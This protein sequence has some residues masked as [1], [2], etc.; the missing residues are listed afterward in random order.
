MKN[1]SLYRPLVKTMIWSILLC[2]A[3]YALILFLSNTTIIGSGME[4]I[5]KIVKIVKFI[6]V[7]IPTILFVVSISK[8]WKG[9]S[10]H[11]NLDGYILSAT[12]ALILFCCVLYM[13][14]TAPI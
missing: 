13:L 2:A 3:S 6:M 5:A 12:Y 7:A 9:N 8:I 1:W 11:Q 10:R 4:L 14:V